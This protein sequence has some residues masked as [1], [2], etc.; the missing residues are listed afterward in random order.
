VARQF[1]SRSRGESNV[2]LAQMKGPSY[3]KQKNTEFQI[4]NSRLVEQEN[5]ELL[6]GM[7]CTVCGFV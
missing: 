2:Y 4:E 6:K 1:F 3:Q 7:H 5:Q